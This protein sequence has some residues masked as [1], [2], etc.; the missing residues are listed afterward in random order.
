M[1]S[2]KRF[3]MLWLVAMAFSS[4]AQF[5]SVT[6]KVGY[7]ISNHFGQ[8]LGNGIHINPIPNFS[9]ATEYRLSGRYGLKPEVIFN[10]EYAI[11]TGPLKLRM[12]MP[13]K[14]NFL[15]LPIS[16]QRNFGEHRNRFWSIGTYTAYLLSMTV[17]GRSMVDG[18][19][20]VNLSQVD[21]FFW[22]CSLGAGVKIPVTAQNKL[23][24]EFKSSF[25]RNVDTGYLSL[26]LQLGYEFG[27]KKS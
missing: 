4:F 14:S 12:E 21:R 7:G 19:H 27:R 5:V 20:Y 2:F 24:I 25:S 17:R 15:A 1:T 23:L 18:A 6:P 16:L 26:W 3:G 8:F 10:Q 9:I 11:V 22:G 13:L